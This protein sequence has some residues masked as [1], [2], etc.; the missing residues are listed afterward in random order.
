MSRAASGAAS[1]D[2]LGPSQSA[3]RGGQGVHFKCDLKAILSKA[4]SPSETYF[5]CK[6]PL[7][8]VQQLDDVTRNKPAVRTAGDTSLLTAQDA[9]DASGIFS[10]LRSKWAQ[11][12]S[13]PHPKQHA[14][15]TT[16]RTFVMQI[17]IWPDASTFSS[18]T[19]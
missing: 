2:H 15:S 16:L 5:E 17:R 10:F 8:I 7:L 6:L 3:A 12:V 14:Q 13:V 1:V 9:Q 19:T 11:F 4:Q 18:M